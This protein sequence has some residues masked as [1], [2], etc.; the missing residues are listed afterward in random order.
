L[1][2]KQKCQKGKNHSKNY[3]LVRF[4]VHNARFLSY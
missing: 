3:I 2:K 4:Q 1:R